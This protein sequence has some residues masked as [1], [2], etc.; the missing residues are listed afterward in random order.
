MIS[1]VITTYN[2]E[3]YIIDELESICNQTLKPDCVLISDDGSNDKTVSLVEGF[4]RNRH[5]LNWRV[6]THKNIGWKQNFILALKEVDGDYIFIADQDDIWH[7]NK[8]EFMVNCMR[9]NN[10]IKLLACAYEKFFDDIVPTTCNL[11]PID[12]KNV[13]LSAGIFNTTSP[14]CTYCVQKDFLFRALE[15]A[16]D[17]YPHDALLW[18][19]SALEG[20]RYFLPLKLHYWRKHKDSAYAVESN[21]MKSKQSKIEWTYYADDF[22]NDMLAYCNAMQYDKSINIKII[23]KNLKWNLIRR[24][25]LQGGKLFLG[26]KLLRY[27]RCYARFRQYLYDW[28]LVLRK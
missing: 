18:R 26:I 5:L 14:G 1:I 9:K 4:I 17:N 24:N 19:M 10:R 12:P 2:G 23:E 13:P 8:I 27:I 16:K 6:I 28:Y 20:G 25:F 3:K 22:L 15:Y 21:T 7:P 11:N